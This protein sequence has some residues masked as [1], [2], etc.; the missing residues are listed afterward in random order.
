MASA[1][2]VNSSFIIF[3]I[4]GYLLSLFIYN[5]IDC[6]LFY[7]QTASQILLY[8][9]GFNIIDYIMLI[10]NFSSNSRNFR[11]FGN[12]PIAGEGMQIFTYARHLWPLS[13]EDSLSYHSYCET[14]HPF[15]L[16]ISEDQWHSHL[17][18]TAWQWSRHYLF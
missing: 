17:M 10:W 1:A 18:P 6:S 9:C 2:L 5:Y 12:V 14:G 13:S 7:F 3:L 4:C 11:S 15:I 8:V 16:V